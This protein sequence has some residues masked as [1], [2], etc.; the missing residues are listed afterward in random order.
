MKILLEIPDSKASFFLEML[1]SIAF[2]KKVS[3]L[4]DVKAEQILSIREATSE[5]KQ[6]REGKLKGISSKKLLDAL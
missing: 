5:L 6:I 2:V 3:P 1:K 4:S